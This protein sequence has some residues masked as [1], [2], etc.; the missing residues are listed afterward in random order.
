M[1]P[2]KPQISL[3]IWA[4]WSEPLQFAWIFYECWAT[5]GTACGVSS[6]SSYE[7][8]LVKLPHCWKSHVATH[9]YIHDEEERSDS[10]VEWTTWDQGVAS[11]SLTG[12]T[13]LCHWARHFI[14]FLVLVQTSKHPNLSWIFFVHNQGS[15]IALVRSYLWVPQAARQVKILIFLVKINFFPCMPILFVIQGKCLF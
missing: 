5:D 3:R 6:T 14:L 10:V 2:A 8:T 4:V 15:K 9:F 7:S 13:V 11:S 12:G 1:G